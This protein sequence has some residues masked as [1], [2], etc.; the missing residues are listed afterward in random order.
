MRPRLTLSLFALALAPVVACSVV[1]ESDEASSDSAITDEELA[2]KALFIVGAKVQN[3]QSQCQRC[4]DINIATLTKWHDD[5]KAALAVLGDETKSVEERINW[6]RRDPHDT[7][8]TFSPSK[9]GLLTAGTHFAGA[10]TV[11]KDRTPQLYK[12]AQILNK[13]FEGKRDLYKTFRE[14]TIMPIEAT[15]DRLTASEYDTVATWMSKDMPKL[16]DI[17]HEEARPTT[18]T[19]DFAALKDHASNI[20]SKS[21]ASINRD[22][23]LAMFACATRDKPL[24]C[25]NQQF[26]GKDIFPLSTTKDYAKD[27]ATAGGSLRIL[28]ELDYRTFFWMRSSADGRFVANGLSGHYPGQEETGDGGVIADLAA[29]LDP[30]GPKTRDIGASARYDPDFFPDNQGFMFQG[31]PNG[32]SFCRQSLLTK[33]PFV[34][35]VGFNE[36][37]CGRLGS[38]GLYQTVGQHMGDSD[39]ADNFIVNGKFASDNPGQTASDH[40]LATTFGPD[41]KAIIH[42]MFARGNDAPDGY[43]VKQTVEL[44]VKFEGDIMMSRS[45]T[46]LGARVAGENGPLGYSIR[47]LGAV[48]G[49]DGYRFS[50]K[51]IGRVCMA[52]NKANFSFDERFLTTHHYLTRDDFGSDA[53]FAGYKDK[54]ASDIWVAD[55][56]TGKK[57]RITHMAPGQ[58]A[59]YPHFRSDGWLYFIVRD[60]NAKKEY[61]VASDFALKATAETPTP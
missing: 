1:A 29:A 57:T 55:F 12:D 2:T 18:C 10:S 27:W 3:S 60:A 35:R 26:G 59:L 28:R 56:V 58:F 11:S 19:D 34:K 4:H 38:V 49:P 30:A 53:D 37:E 14:Q 23:G 8:S 7:T 6:M 46:L 41:A 32:G 17:L 25:F 33:S 31:T 45:T 52:G 50:L 47:E 44:G 43:E 15:Y 51:P 48:M 40:D 61:I 24:E 22:R 54:G 13:L 42:V 39:I 20:R 9:L 5:Y 16:T 21:W 36:P